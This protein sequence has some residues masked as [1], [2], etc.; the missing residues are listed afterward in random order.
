MD[1]EIPGRDENQTPLDGFPPEHQQLPPLDTKERLGPWGNT[2]SH[3]TKEPAEPLDGNSG[4]A[5]K[6][7]S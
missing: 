1:H 5:N 3:S 7:W 2:D 6:G 4:T